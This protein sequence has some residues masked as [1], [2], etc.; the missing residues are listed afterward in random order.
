M[1]TTIKTNLMLGFILAL[2]IISFA[3]FTRN[4]RDFG[5]DLKDNLNELMMK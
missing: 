4:R 3:R 2:A 5:Y 1:K